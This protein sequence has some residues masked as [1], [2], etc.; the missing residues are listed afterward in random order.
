MTKEHIKIFTDESG[1]KYVGQHIDKMDKNHRDD[2]QMN[3][4]EGHMYETGE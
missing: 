4:N 2:D 1:M 3:T